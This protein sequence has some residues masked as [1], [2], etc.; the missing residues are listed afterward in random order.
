MLAILLMASDDLKESDNL[1]LLV[2]NYQDRL[3][4]RAFKLLGNR[5]DAEDA[6]QQLFLA[7]VKNHSA[8]DINNPA[9]LAILLVAVEN[10]AKNI[11]K[12]KTRTGAEPLHDSVPEAPSALSAEDMDLLKNA[13]G[14]LPDELR[15][16]IILNFFAGYTTKEI[17]KY[18]NV[19]QDTVQ[20][21]IKRAKDMLREMLKEEISL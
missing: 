3:Y 12:S 11:L 14:R 7:L 4:N 6:V 2:R 19:K 21:R 17:A 10:K 5:E 13:I 1:T 16:A 9:C 15:E 20:K 18:Q 8:P